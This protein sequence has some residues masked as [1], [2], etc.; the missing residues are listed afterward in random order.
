MTLLWIFWQILISYCKFLM[1][2]P[3]KWG[4]LGACIIILSQDIHKNAGRY[5]SWI[6]GNWQ[7]WQNWWIHEK[8]FSS[9][10]WIFLDRI[11]VLAPSIPH[12]KG[13]GMR[14]LQYEI[15]IYQKINNKATMTR[16]SYFDFCWLTRYALFFHNVRYNNKQN[17]SSVF[18]LGISSQT[19]RVY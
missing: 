16:S 3:L 12:F 18:W 4:I 2:R 11:I 10:L 1:P 5:L 19:E 13:L 14:N 15:S 17:F 9:I 7:N 8:L 6:S